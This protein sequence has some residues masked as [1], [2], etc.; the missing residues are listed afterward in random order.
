VSSLLVF[1]MLLVWEITPL[2]YE[3]RSRFS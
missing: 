3:N 2:L 1:L